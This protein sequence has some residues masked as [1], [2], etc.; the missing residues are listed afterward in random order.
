MRNPY[1]M[2]N[3]CADCLIE[4]ALKDNAENEADARRNLREWLKSYTCDTQLGAMLFNVNYHISYIPSKVWDMPW[5]RLDGTKPRYEDFAEDEWTR[6]YVRA[7]EMGIEPY[8][9]AM[10]ETRKTGA[11]VWFSVRMNEFHYLRFPYACASL[12]KERPDLRLGEKQAFDYEKKEVR[13][14]YLMYIKEICENYEIDGIELDLWRGPEFFHKPVTS[15][16]AQIIT[17]FLKEIRAVVKEIAE[18][19]NRTIRISARTDIHPDLALARGFDSAQ[20]VADGSVDVLTLAVF[21][22]P[23]PYA[24]FI[25]EWVERMTEKGIDR[26]AYGINVCADLASFCMK[27]DEPGIKWLC[28]D[29][30]NLKGFAATHFDLGADGLYTF[31]INNRDYAL[32]GEARDVDFSEFMSREKVKK[33]ARRHILT[34]DEENT[35]E[36]TQLKA[37]LDVGEALK[38]ALHTSDAPQEGRYLIE[39]GTN[40]RVDWKVSINGKLCQYAGIPKGKPYDAAAPLNIKEI[41]G[42]AKYMVL[43]EP[44]ESGAVKDG[45]NT[46]DL[47]NVSEEKVEVTWFSVSITQDR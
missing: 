40:Q 4:I 6:E 11:E 35:A 29:T 8:R 31:N 12:W 3:I 36:R 43:Y 27:Y 26:S 46:F 44:A 14:Y 39:I 9:I 17:D 33:G 15:E 41:S 18:A 19:K 38:L 16:K 47:Q 42:T 32:P 23:T 34:Y 10:E 1:N 21:W 28:P 30:V 45:W 24:A 13:D 37:K 25:E 20:W 5:Q 22:I 2:T 7:H